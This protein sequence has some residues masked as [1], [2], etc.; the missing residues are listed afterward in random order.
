[1]LPKSTSHSNKYQGGLKIRLPSFYLS[2]NGKNGRSHRADLRL[3]LIL[4][5]FLFSVVIFC[6]YC[7]V[8][9]LHKNYKAYI[10]HIYIHI[11]IHVIL[12]FIGE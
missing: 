6:E 12:G 9:M 3:R 11:H 2:H 7:N 10:L 1:M 4:G 8:K 5:G